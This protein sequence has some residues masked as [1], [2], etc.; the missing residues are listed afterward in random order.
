MILSNNKNKK[1]SSHLYKCPGVIYSGILILASLVWSEI[2]FMEFSW[3]CL[4]DQDSQEDSDMI[5][6]WGSPG[7][8]NHEE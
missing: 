4:H 2:D 6:D 1:T 5:Q 3:F 8:V 7:S